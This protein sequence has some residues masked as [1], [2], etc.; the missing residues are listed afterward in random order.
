MDRGDLVPDEVMVGLIAERVSS[1]E[2]SDGFILDGFP[3]TIGQGGAL[4][5]KLTELDRQLTA[6][7]LIEVPTRRS[8][9]ASA[10]G[11]CASRRA[12]SS[13][14]SSIRPRTRASATWT[15]RGSRSATTTSPT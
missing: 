1:E 15:A 7:I 9:G 5:A 4:D 3:R 14:W 10:A 2:A 6:V 13:I 12:T 11:A 8:S